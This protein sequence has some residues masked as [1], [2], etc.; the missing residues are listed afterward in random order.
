MKRPAKRRPAPRP[1]WQEPL[2]LKWETTGKC[3]RCQLPIESLQ[4]GGLQARHVHDGSP[5]CGESAKFAY[6]PLRM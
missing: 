5:L 3:G 2:A 4:P 1:D 6:F